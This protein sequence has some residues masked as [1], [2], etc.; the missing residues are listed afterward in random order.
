MKSVGFLNYFQAFV[1]YFVI[2]WRRILGF[3]Y[4]CRSLHSQRILE[5][6]MG[7]NVSGI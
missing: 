4:L 7:R 2:N 3:P 1:F 6:K 5:L